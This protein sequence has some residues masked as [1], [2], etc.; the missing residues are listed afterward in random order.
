MAI[1]KKSSSRMFRIHSRKDNFD[2]PGRDHEDHK[3]F[4]AFQNSR[5]LD[6]ITN[7]LKWQLLV[8][9]DPKLTGLYFHRPT[10]HLPMTPYKPDR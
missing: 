2:F 6:Q 5:Y 7:L 8:P 9:E 3:F 4:L 1:L 10:L